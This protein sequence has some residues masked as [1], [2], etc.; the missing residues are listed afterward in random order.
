MGQW[1]VGCGDSASGRLRCHEL[2]VTL[3]RYSLSV[4]QASSTFDGFTAETSEVIWHASTWGMEAG[5]AVVPVWH[6]TPRANQSD[7]GT[8]LQ[9]TA[10]PPMSFTCQPD[11]HS[12]TPVPCWDVV[13]P[14][15]VAARANEAQAGFAQESV[16]SP[17]PK[18]PCEGLT[19]SAR[20]PECTWRGRA[21]FR[22]MGRPPFG[23]PSLPLT[24][25]PTTTPLGQAACT[26]GSAQ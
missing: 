11:V 18:V 8:V 17:S 26:E 16:C 13:A 19:T 5:G 6:C 14:A 20:V 10:T 12:A 9:P 4:A 7:M 25:T 24:C 1:A 2:H 3:S 23:A 21:P 15:A 22:R